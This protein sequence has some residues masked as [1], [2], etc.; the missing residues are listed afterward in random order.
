MEQ[1]ILIIEFVLESSELLCA[2]IPS[3]MY[4]Y[5]YSLEQLIPT[6]KIIK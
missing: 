3:Q 6:Q 2:Y 4:Q 5:S 1:T